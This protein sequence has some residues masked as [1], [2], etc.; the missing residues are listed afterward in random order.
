MCFWIGSTLP[1]RIHFAS[2]DVN[3]FHQLKGASR[4][5]TK[6]LFLLREAQGNKQDLEMLRLYGRGFFVIVRK[7]A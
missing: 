1:L 3:V 2:S 5:C 7:Q 6:V 4:T